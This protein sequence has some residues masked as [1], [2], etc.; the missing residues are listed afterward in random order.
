MKMHCRHET[1]ISVDY[2]RKVSPMMDALYQVYGK[3]MDGLAQGLQRGELYDYDVEDCEFGDT[4]LEFVLD[5]FEEDVKRVEEEVKALTGLEIE[6]D[7]HYSEFPDCDI[8]DGHFWS[9]SNAFI[10]NPK[11]DDSLFEKMTSGCL[12]EEYD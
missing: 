10:R 4:C 6:L 5:K 2:L 3:C 11:L 8:A 7:Y 12:I 9:V 1:V